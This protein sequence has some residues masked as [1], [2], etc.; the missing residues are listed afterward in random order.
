MEKR[1]V[2]VVDDEAGITG[3]VRLNLEKTGRYE[4]REMCTSTGVGDAARQF[5]PHLILL[6]ML[7]PGKDG[8]QVLAELRAQEETKQVPVIFLTAAMSKESVNARQGKVAGLPVIA[9]PI[10]ARE[11]I[12]RIEEVIGTETVLEFKI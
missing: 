12:D 11:L 5:G 1:R 10:R 3:L 7:M 6:D 4:V 8:G 2:L 9:K